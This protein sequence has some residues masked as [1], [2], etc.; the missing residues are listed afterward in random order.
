[1]ANID[2]TIAEK[3][4]QE[5]HEGGSVAAASTLCASRRRAGHEGVSPHHRHDRAAELARRSHFDAIDLPEYADCWPSCRWATPSTTWPRESCGTA[6]I[7]CRF[8]TR[9]SQIFAANGTR[10]G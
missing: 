5:L 2:G 7:N 3:G 9:V 1:V 10:I 4:L 8:R 6:S